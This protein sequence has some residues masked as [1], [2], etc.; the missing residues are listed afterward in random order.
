MVLC[1]KQNKYTGMLNCSIANRN[2]RKI[3]DFYV[4]KTDFYIV[5][6]SYNNQLGRRAFWI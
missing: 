5:F 1:I 3:D 6:C 2:F 4:E